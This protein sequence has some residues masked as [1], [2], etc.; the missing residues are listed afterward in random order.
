MNESR[1]RYD[2]DG[3]IRI[4]STVRLPELEFARSESPLRPD[5]VI[6]RGLVGGPLPRTRRSLVSE[7]GRITW[8]EH[9][10]SLGGN[11][12]IEFG[13]P[14]RVTV[15][16]LLAMS[17]HVVYTNLVEPLLRFMLVRRGRVLLHAATVRLDGQTVMLSA[18]TDTGKTTTILRLLQSHGGIFY[19]DDMVVLDADGWVTRY[20]KPLTI[21]A[22]TVRATPRSRLGTAG[23]LALPLQSRLHS[24]GVRGAG[25]R[26]GRLNL[27][28]MSM[29]AAVQALIPP[30]KYAVTDLVDCEVGRRT[31]MEHVFLIERG[32]ETAISELHG[33]AAVDALLRNTEDAY[34]FPPYPSVARHICLEG[35]DHAALKRQERVILEAALGDRRVTRV[36]AAGYAWAEIIVD[37]LAIGQQV[38]QAVEQDV[39]P[40]AGPVAQQPEAVGVAAELVAN[41]AA[42]PVHQPGGEP[43]PVTAGRP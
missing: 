12:Q 1:H 2:I 38:E 24:R 4:R 10:G 28:I 30:P 32:S 17:P 36:V 29:N 34:G 3:S 42:A 19:S 25:K 39:K 11:F 23:R 5:L 14:V 33:P 16:P 41:P 40:V 37:R 31:R 18:E 6:E 20:P 15:G 9:L 21:S 8:R 27:P 13:D 7:A 26:M 35:V 43:E 22:H